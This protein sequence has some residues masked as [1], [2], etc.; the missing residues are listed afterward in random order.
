M[1]PSLRSPAITAVSTLLR[2]ARPLAALR[3]CRPRFSGLGLSLGMRRRFPQFNARAQNRIAP[4]HAVPSGP[5][6][7]VQTDP[8]QHH[9]PVRRHLA[10]STL[11]GVGCASPS[12]LLPDAFEAPFRNA[13]DPGFDQRRLRWFATSCKPIA[14]TNPISHAVSAAH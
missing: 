1:T 5:N 11:N 7:R 2:T 3:Y 12:C 8:A 13:H 4:P 10:L 14:G 6:R 9:S